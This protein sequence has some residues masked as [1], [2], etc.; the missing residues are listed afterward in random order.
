MD[1]EVMLIAVF[2]DVIKRSR[3]IAITCAKTY[4]RAK[5][6]NLMSAAAKVLVLMSKKRNL[7]PVR[8]HL[9]LLFCCR[10]VDSCCLGQ[11]SQADMV[12]TF[13]GEL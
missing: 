11:L 5:V 9:T 1:G 3:T 6:H 13:L 7:H 12:R 2:D 10:A 8:D 4:A